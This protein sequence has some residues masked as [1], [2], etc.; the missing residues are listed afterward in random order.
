MPKVSLT[1]PNVFSATVKAYMRSRK[2]K[3]ID[4][5][6]HLGVSRYTA[7][8]KLRVPVRKLTVGEVETLCRSVGMSIDEGFDQIK[9]S[10]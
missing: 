4:L 6:F 9:K 2:V 7:S 8:S 5:A 3:T 1:K 10:L